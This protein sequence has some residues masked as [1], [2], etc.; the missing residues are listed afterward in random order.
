MTTRLLSRKRLD[1]TGDAEAQYQMGLV[2]ENG[3]GVKQDHAA[4]AEWY[5][6]AAEQGHAIA[7]Y[8]LGFLYEIGKGVPQSHLMRF[9]FAHHILRGLRADSLD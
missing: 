3:S 8:F 2:Y 1:E 4:A 5:R 9:A 7:Q 6:K